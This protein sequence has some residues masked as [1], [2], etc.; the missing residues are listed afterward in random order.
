MPQLK[1]LI[2]REQIAQRVAEMGAEITRDFSGESV[3]FVGV[4]KGASIFLSDLA[5]HVDLDAAFDFIG[6]ASYGNRP[7]PAQELISGWDSTGEVRLTKDVDQSMRDKN[8]ILVFEGDYRHRRRNPSSKTIP[9]LNKIN[10]SDVTYYLFK[11]LTNSFGLR[12]PRLP[13]ATT[14][15][16][17]H[18]TCFC[19]A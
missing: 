8:V 7:S 17:A 10:R 19:L 11:P 9:E 3:I 2:S 1:V 12:L 16:P 15:S 14:N 13:T 18:W 6:V 4:L 5:R